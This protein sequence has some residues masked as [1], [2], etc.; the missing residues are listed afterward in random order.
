MEKGEIA[1]WGRPIV[2]FVFD[3]LVAEV[4]NER[5]ERAFIRLHRWAMAL[6]LWAFNIT[7]LDWM[8][9]VMGRNFIVNVITWH[10]APFAELVNAKLWDLDVPV[11]D[12]M[13]TEYRLV[14]HRFGTDPEVRCV[15]DPDPAHRFGYGFKGREFST[16]WTNL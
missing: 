10:P 3:G 16:S 6:D 15:Y 13:S 14:T 1:A 11:L 7:V 9:Q 2:Y 5:T 12:V 4:S 8:H